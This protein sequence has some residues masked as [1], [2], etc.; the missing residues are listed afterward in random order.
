MEGGRDEGRG[1]ADR[2][3]DERVLCYV[4][5]G[6]SSSTPTHIR[7]LPPSPSLPPR[8][9]AHTHAY[10]HTHKVQWALAARHSPGTGRA[11]RRTAAPC[12]SPCLR[13]VP[14]PRWCPPAPQNPH[15]RCS[16]L[17]QTP[18]CSC[19]ACG[20]A[21][22]RTPLAL[23]ARAPLIAAIRV[24]Y[25]A[26]YILY[27]TFPNTTTG[28]APSATAARTLQRSLQCSIPSLLRAN[29]P[30]PEFRERS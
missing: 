20:R 8:M 15:V 1:E 26:A 30:Q 12:T 16:A 2:E 25:I 18:S 21:H 27:S 10:T 3:T 23:L 4:P 28:Q 17:A 5:T 22:A 14:A 11:S 9:R 19:E 6:N 29:G 13:P 7:S 24:R